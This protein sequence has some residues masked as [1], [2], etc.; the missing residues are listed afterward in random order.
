MDNSSEC[1]AKWWLT[2]HLPH[3]CAPLP[4]Y[5]VYLQPAELI[6][7]M[8]VHVRDKHPFP[9]RSSNTYKFREKKPA[10]IHTNSKRKPCKLTD[11]Y[12]EGNPANRQTYREGNAAN[13]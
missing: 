12:R 6:V 2:P 13:I 3:V 11:I 1:Y 10:N 7:E 8:S 5:F 4:L 9:K